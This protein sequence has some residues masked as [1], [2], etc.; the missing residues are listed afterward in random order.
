MLA[1]RIHGSEIKILN[2]VSHGFF[3]EKPQE[4]AEVLK[5]WFRSH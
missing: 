1:D 3:W 2:G 5:S 4:T